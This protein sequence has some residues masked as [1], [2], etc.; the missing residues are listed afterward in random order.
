MLRPSGL[1]SAADSPAHDAGP[2]NPSTFVGYFYPVDGVVVALRAV[3]FIPLKLRLVAAPTLDRV[4]DILA[5]C[6]L[7]EMRRIAARRVIARVHHIKGMVDM[8]IVKEERQLVSWPC[9][10]AIGHG[11]IAWTGCLPAFVVRPVDLPTP[12]WQDGATRDELRQV[13]GIRPIGA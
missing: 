6:S 11:A 10:A 3:R 2:L 1:F 8:P 13:V 7:R 9:L 5:A 12:I 4:S